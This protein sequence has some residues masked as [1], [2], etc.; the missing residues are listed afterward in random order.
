MNST[1]KT[2]IFVNGKVI[3]KVIA[4]TF[5]KAVSGSKHFLRS[6]KAIALAATALADAEAAGATSIAITDI[7]T[8][9]TY[10]AALAHFRRYSFDMQRGKF[11][12]QKA[13]TLDR[14]DVSGGKVAHQVEKN[15][16]AKRIPTPGED[17]AYTAAFDLPLMQLHFDIF[18]GLRP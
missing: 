16:R 11:E 4:G 2:P 5:C 17:P 15:K 10:A 12:P 14:W 18:R 3:G 1:V 6:P 8:G 7:E 9:L 13:L